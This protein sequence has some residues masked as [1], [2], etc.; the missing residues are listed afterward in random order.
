VIRYGMS[1]RPIKW[2]SLYAQ[3]NQGFAPPSPRVDPINHTVYGP[4][5]SRD[6]E[7]GIRLFFFNDRLSLSADI[8][9]MNLGGIITPYPNV[10]TQ[11]SFQSG[12]IIDN[13]WET[14]LQGE[15]TPQWSITA[16]VNQCDYVL[17]NGRQN[18]LAARDYGNFFTKYTFNRGQGILNNLSVGLGE[19]YKFRMVDGYFINPVNGALTERYFPNIQV[20]GALAEYRWQR[21][22][23]KLSVTNLFNKFYY[24]TESSSIFFRGDTRHV[25]FTTDYKF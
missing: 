14:T 19:Y 20:W 2:V 25:T 17:M 16:S 18:F 6:S 1:V 10:S 7:G 21:L 4:S 22:S 11:G 15:I 13:G 5:T 3:Y 8:F 12:G 24:N 9:R 23:F